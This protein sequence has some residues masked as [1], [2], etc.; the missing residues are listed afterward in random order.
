MTAIPPAKPKLDTLPNE[1]IQQI[2]YSS[3]NPYLSFVSRKLYSSL[4]GE[5][6]QRSFYRKIVTELTFELVFARKYEAILNRFQRDNITA[7]IMSEILKRSEITPKE[8]WNLIEDEPGGLP[9]L[10]VPKGTVVPPHL[11]GHARLVAASA[12]RGSY[13][14]FL[15]HLEIRRPRGLMPRFST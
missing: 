10:T 7:K 2:W 9:V 13:I 1:I 12:A 11:R 14:N 3:G 5:H 6:V 4:N 15:Q 8:I